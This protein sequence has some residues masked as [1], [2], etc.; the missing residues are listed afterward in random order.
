MTNIGRF[1]LLGKECRYVDHTA[2]EASWVFQAAA[3][4]QQMM[5][6]QDADVLCPYTPVEIG[7][8]GLYTGD[9]VFLSRVIHTRARGVDGE[10]EVI[11]RMKEA[12]H[13]R[14]MPKFLR[15]ERLTHTITK[16]QIVTLLSEEVEPLVPRDAKIVPR[17]T[18]DRHMLRSFKGRILKDPLWFWARLRERNYYASILAGHKEEPPPFPQL[19]KGFSGPVSRLPDSIIL[20]FTEKLRTVGIKCFSDYP[21]YVR[22]DR[23]AHVSYMNLGWETDRSDIIQTAEQY[24]KEVLDFRD[25]HEADVLTHQELPLYIRENLHLLVESDVMIRNEFISKI[26]QIPAGTTVKVILVSKDRKCARTLLYDVRFDERHNY[27]FIVVDPII[28]NTGRTPSD[29]ELGTPLK[30]PTETIELVDAGSTAY[31]RAVMAD[32]QMIRDENIPAKDQYMAQVQR[33]LSIPFKF[34]IEKDPIWMAVIVS[35]PNL[36][37]DN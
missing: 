15:N 25:Q 8:D 20:E 17:T 30:D 34:W 36:L 23:V 14:Y 31:Q 6:P 9:P 18:S 35:N 21:Y 13:R 1:S 29:E 27:E 3:I 26:K 37:K 11:Y 24:Q 16:H 2:Q 32:Y 10:W 33:L 22:E 7:G 19:E 5:V 12:L 28:Y 4:I